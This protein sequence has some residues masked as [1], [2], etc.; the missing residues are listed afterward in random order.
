MSS[1]WSARVPFRM[2][3]MAA[4]VRDALSVGGAAVVVFFLFALTGVSWGAELLV[5]AGAA[6]KPP[7]EE[8]AGSFTRRTGVTVK[9]TFGG[10]GF[11]LSQMALAGR[12]DVYFPG[13][14]DYMEIAKA[15]GIVPPQTERIVAYLVPA[16]VVQKGNPKNIKSLHDL[17][18]PGLRVAIADPEGVCVGLYAVE[19]V[20]RNFSPEAK[21]AFRRNL[22]SYT[23]SCEKTAAAVSLKAVDAVIGWEVFRRWDP[24]RLEV[25]PLKKGEIARIGYLPIGVTKFASDRAL[26]QRF[27][28]FVLSPEGKA[29]FRR[30]G[31]F[32]SP[33]EARSWIGAPKPVGGEYRPPRD[34]IRR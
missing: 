26:A 8:I 13:S 23:D 5:F 28:D 1:R 14:S 33:E 30:H 29:V 32:I 31:Y 4:R 17:T 18:R 22:V 19:I 3:A 34:W 20:E 10:S 9:T 15:R 7:L 2:A 6:A 25:I 24:H 21:A 11:V 12:G 27:V 16:V